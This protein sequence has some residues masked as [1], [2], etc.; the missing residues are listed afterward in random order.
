MAI[1]TAI[2]YYHLLECRRGPFHSRAHRGTSA[3]IP[4]LADEKLSLCPRCGEEGQGD[5]S[6]SSGG[7]VPGIT[8][9][10]RW[11]YVPRPRAWGCPRL[12]TRW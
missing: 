4:A 6:D 3:A 7:R 2:P 9:G 10:A 1:G 11:P 5:L 8:S 12:W